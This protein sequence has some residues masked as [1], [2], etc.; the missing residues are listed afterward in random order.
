MP[1][2]ITLQKCYPYPSKQ[3]WHTATAIS[4]QCKT[5]LE[6]N[7]SLPCHSHSNAFTVTAISRGYE[8][9]ECTGSD[10]LH[11]SMHIFTKMTTVH[12]PP[13]CPTTI[14]AISKQNNKT[15]KNSTN[16][17]KN[18]ITIMHRH[19]KVKTKLAKNPNNCH[20]IA[21]D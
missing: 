14:P 3:F 4:A 2:S 15:R 13:Y 18:G 19:T 10:H 12:G 5:L 9:W 21:M 1:P 6:F 20:V 8:A 17:D 7:P 11:V 16:Q